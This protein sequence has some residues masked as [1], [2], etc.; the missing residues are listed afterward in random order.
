MAAEITEYDALRDVDAA[1]WLALDE[2]ERICLVTEFH[3]AV[4][5]DLPDVSMH[6]MLHVIIENQIA[7]GDETPVA[8]K[9]GQLRAEGLDRHDAVHALASV[10]VN[11]IFEGLQGTEP[12][13]GNDAY[14]SDLEALTAESWL[15]GAADDSADNEDSGT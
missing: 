3:E 5:V 4:E 8:R 7:L 15:Q 1:E 6:A 11:H 9:L 12:A 13:R 14:Y 2:D 10:L